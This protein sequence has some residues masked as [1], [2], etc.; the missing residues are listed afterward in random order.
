MLTVVSS[1]QSAVSERHPSLAQSKVLASAVW[2]N[3]QDETKAGLLPGKTTSRC[4]EIFNISSN[5]RAW[6]HD[7]SAIMCK[8]LQEAV[9][10]YLFYIIGN[11]E[12][13]VWT[14]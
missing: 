2:S 4:S 11:G 8:S 5:H 10:T 12:Y 13:G 14:V 9:L 6:W 7:D 1:G 3:S